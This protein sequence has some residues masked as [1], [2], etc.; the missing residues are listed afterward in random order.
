MIYMK[1]TRSEVFEKAEDEDM[2]VMQR[3]NREKKHY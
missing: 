1:N 3:W 2:E